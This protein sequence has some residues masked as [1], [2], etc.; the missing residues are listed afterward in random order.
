MN[1]DLA[2]APVSPGVN[3]RGELVP[4]PGITPGTALRPV[5]SG[6]IIIIILNISRHALNGLTMLLNLEKDLAR[7]KAND[8]TS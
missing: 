3:S 4:S 8:N 5:G 6:N 7:Q 2:N 1:L